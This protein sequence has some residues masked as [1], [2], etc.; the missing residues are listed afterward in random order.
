[1]RIS[2]LDP[3]DPLGK[4]RRHFEI[5]IDSPFTVLNCRATQANT[6]LPQYGQ[7]GPMPFERQQTSCGCP[8]ADILDR[9][10]S[11][12]FGQLQLVEQQDVLS[13]SGSR[14][15]LNRLSASALPSIPQAAH[16][17]DSLAPGGLP[18]N[19]PRGHTLPSPL[20]RERPIHLI[21][22]PS[23]NPPAFDA[24]E[25]PPPLQN[26]LMTPPPHY[27]AIIGTPSVDGLA[28]YFARLAD[29]EDTGRPQMGDRSGSQE[30][31]ATLRGAQ[32]PTS[33]DEGFFG[34][35][36]VVTGSDLPVNKDYD[37]DSSS[38]A[39]EE[40]GPARPHRG[41]RVNVANPRTPG[42]RLI[43]SRSLEIERPAMR[44]DMGSLTTRRR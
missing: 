18:V 13:P 2:R 11:N 33:R 44:L 1:M 22:C 39:D 34:S 40:D 24:D 15:G 21:R 32:R 16:V 31:V 43:P 9:S 26:D 27:D 6:A 23:Y 38:S 4:R 5:S 7:D 28:D 25:P 42:G 14:L 3:E 41:G 8:D 10:A 37:D 20:E 17:H 30:S 12:S 35:N 19:R 29:Y 36:E